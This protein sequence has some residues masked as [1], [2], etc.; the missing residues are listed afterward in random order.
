MRDDGPVR[1]GDQPLRGWVVNADVVVIG[2]GV[3]GLSVAW[4]ASLA[5]LSVVV[6]DDDRPGKGSWAAAG[7][8]APL[9]EAMPGEE[10]LLSLSLRSAAMYPAFVEELE[11]AAGIAVGYRACGS[12]LVAVDGDDHRWLMELAVLHE[13]LGVV[14]HR[15]DRRAARELEPALDPGIRSALVIDG[16]HQVDNRRLLR[17]LRCA[18]VNAGVRFESGTAAVILSRGRAA[19]VR[20]GSGLAVSAANVVVAAGCWSAGVEGVPVEA[21]PAVRPVKGQILRLRCDSTRPF[22]GRTVRALVHGANVYLV[23]RVD[24]EIVVGGTVE[25]RGFDTMV[26]AGAVHDLLRDARAV[27]PE[28]AECALI[29]VH[30]GF[31][32]GSPDNT[33]IIGQTAVDGLIVATGHY[34]NGVLL[35]PVTAEIVAGILAT[36]GQAV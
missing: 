17:A 23:P 4:R 16:D 19:G 3:I 24:G 18:A 2:G 27:V 6:V 32:P 5:G 14:S 21:R 26:T 10:R 7:M 36:A 31:R 8:L 20:I 30:A 15:V 25:D 13:R 28:I 1:R 11:A 29:E 9:A 22:L 33:P 35:T 12:V 34:R